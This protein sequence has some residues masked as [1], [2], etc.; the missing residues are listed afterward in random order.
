MKNA[1]LITSRLCRAFCV[2]VLVFLGSQ[3]SANELKINIVLEGAG[4]KAENGMQ[5]SVHYE[6]RLRD[7]TVFDG[8]KPLG[9]PFSFVLG[10]GQVIKGWDRGILGMK[11]GEKRVLTIPP[12]LGYGARG[13]GSAIPPNATLVFDVEMIKMTWPLTLQQASNQDVQK[14]LQNGAVLIDI[15]RPDEWQKTGVIDGAALITAFTKSGELHPKFQQKFMLLIID[16]D[17]SIMLYCRTGNRTTNLGNALVKRLGFSNVSHLSA[18][19]TGWQ[20]EGPP[21][22]SYTPGTEKLT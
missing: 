10:V 17:T 18:G 5:I 22:I 20:K 4:A 8:S 2:F 7:G 12:E 3:I 11:E 13:A 9:A 21:V 1:M 6:G 19:I 14:S 15:R 16:S